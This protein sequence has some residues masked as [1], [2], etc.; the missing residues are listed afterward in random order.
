MEV[1]WGRR[2]SERWG[3]ATREVGKE[4]AKETRES[5]GEM[6]DCGE[7]GWGRKRRLHGE[8]EGGKERWVREGKL[9]SEEMGER[10]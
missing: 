8:C 9:G 10:M 2:G 7:E 5:E 6:R 1:R 4:K 3:K